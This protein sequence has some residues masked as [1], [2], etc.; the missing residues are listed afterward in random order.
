M[1]THTCSL[2]P[3]RAA[4]AAAFAAMALSSIA[5]AGCATQ[6]S[7]AAVDTST[8]VVVEMSDRFIAL[9]N[10]TGSP[11]VNVSVVVL[12]L[13]GSPFTKIVPRIDNQQRH[14]IALKDLKT[15]QGTT[16]NLVFA[17]PQTVLV[18]A[19]NLSGQRFETKVPWR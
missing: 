7:A 3:T 4:F 5:A 17:Q 6:G 2:T 12:P 19:T 14:E 13:Q 11:L 8:P 16:L 15:S 9:R 18:S 10:H 1:K